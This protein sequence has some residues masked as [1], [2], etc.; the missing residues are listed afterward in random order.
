MIG[1]PGET[2]FT[3]QVGAD[4]KELEKAGSLINESKTPIALLGRLASRS[5]ALAPLEKFISKARIPA[6]SSEQAFSALPKR[7][8][9]F[10]GTL[11]LYDDERSSGLFKKA[12]L[13]ILIEPDSEIVNFINSMRDGQGLPPVIQ[14]SSLPSMIHSFVSVACPLAGSPG[15]ILSDLAEMIE[16]NKKSGK[17][18]W[19]DEVQAHKANVLI[20]TRTKILDHR[21][22]ALAQTFA[23]IN[24]SMGH[25]DFVVCEGN[26]ALLAAKLYLENHAPGKAILIPEHA[27][28]GSGFPI[29]MGIK[30]AREKAKVFL[31]SDRENFKY[32]CREF[33]TASRYGLGTCSIIFPDKEPLDEYEPEF[34]AMA[35]SLG[36][37]GISIQEPVEEITEEIINEAF[38]LEAGACLE[39]KS[40]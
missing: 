4:M 19:I 26:E 15:L 18:E 34:A 16:K 38:D 35:E 24:K 17:S 21:L 37:K 10:L 29:S 20:K 1:K 32:H 23:A 22:R 7:S 39:V 33:Q 11:D 5:E 28:A 12:D 40:F 2:R 13:M 9:D 14:L 36:V 27:P 25:D 31:V 6:F 30:A 3:G 8:E